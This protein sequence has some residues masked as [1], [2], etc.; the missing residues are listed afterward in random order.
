MIKIAVFASASGTNAENIVRHFSD[1]D[2]IKIQLIL[3]NNANAGVIER[4]HRLH[5]PIE[6]FSKKELESSD[7]I[8]DILKAGQI[9]FIVLA[10]FLLLIPQNIIDSYRGRI[11]NIHPALLPLN[12]GK[13]FYGNNVHQAVISSGAIMSG[14]TIHHVNEKFDEGEIIFQAACHVSK[15]ESPETLAQKIHALEYSYLPI[16]IEKMIRTI[17]HNKSE[18]A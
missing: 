6:V 15:E 2:R 1:N 4:A 12:G 7:R 9:D 16:V 18:T 8:T 5:I 13:G 11:I 3:T 14:I 17:F 10:G